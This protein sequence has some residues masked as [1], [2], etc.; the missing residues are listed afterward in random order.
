MLLFAAIA[1]GLLLGGPVAIR[2]KQSNRSPA[3][4][5]RRAEADCIVQGRRYRSGEALP[6]FDHCNFFACR[7]GA[8]EGTKMA[9]EPRPSLQ[10]A[11]VP[12]REAIPSR[13]DDGTR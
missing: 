13:Q 1:G 2:S 12:R 9:C 10:R 11:V 4:I 8:V 5:Q 3:P 6:S 7:D